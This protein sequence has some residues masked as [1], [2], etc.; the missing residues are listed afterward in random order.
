MA[1]TLDF[2]LRCGDRRQAGENE[3]KTDSR[4]DHGLVP[5]CAGAWQEQIKNISSFVKRKAAL[6]AGAPLL[7]R[8]APL[9]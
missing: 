4:N 8:G 6:R 5:S 1:W 9:I 7:S 3:S 2:A